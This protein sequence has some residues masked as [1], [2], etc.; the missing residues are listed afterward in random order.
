MN[1]PGGIGAALAFVARRSRTINEFA[2][3]DCRAIY[4]LASGEMPSRCALLRI[5]VG[6][7]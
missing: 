5:A 6:G 3:A 7:R 1:E 4:L 2:C